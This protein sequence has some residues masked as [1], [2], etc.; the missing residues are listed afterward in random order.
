MSDGARFPGSYQGDE[1]VKADHHD[2]WKEY[3][4]IRAEADELGTRSLERLGKGS[5]RDAGVL[6]ILS[7]SAR[8][9]AITYLISKAKVF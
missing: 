9:E 1:G 6:A 3:M 2:M 4:A 5:P 7:V 8:L